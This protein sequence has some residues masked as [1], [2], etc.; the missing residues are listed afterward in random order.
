M[1]FP[2][3]GILLRKGGAQVISYPSAFTTPTG[4]AHWEQLLRARAIETQCYVIAPAQ[5]GRHNE[6]RH[7]HGRAMVSA[8][9]SYTY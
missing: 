2:E 7:S 9:F 1:R 5:V 8:S 6:Q 3:I 4:T